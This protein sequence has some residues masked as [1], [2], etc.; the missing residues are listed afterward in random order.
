MT[1]SGLPRPPVRALAAF[2]G[3][4]ALGLVQSAELVARAATRGTVDLREAGSGNPGAL[5]ACRLL[6]RRAGL[7][8]AIADVGKGALACALGRALAG[9]G[10]AHAAGVGAVAGHCYP[11]NRGFRGGIGAATSFGQCLATFPAY[12]PVDVAVATTVARLPHLRRP[13]AAALLVSS[14]AWIGAG[15][16]WW[17]RRLPNLWGPR[18]TIALPLANAASAGL[19]ASRALL[20]LRRRGRAGGDLA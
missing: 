20:L 3:G 13:A 9:A 7:A 1:E 16:L 5:N 12:A 4:Y 8:V 10:G 15:S 19:I 14:L 6:G 11:L 2:A 17:R 18:P